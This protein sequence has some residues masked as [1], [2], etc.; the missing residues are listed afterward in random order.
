MRKESEIKERL[1]S[2]KKDL[3]YLKTWNDYADH[4]EQAG[5]WTKDLYRSERDAAS[6][7]ATNY[8]N[9]IR[10]LEWVLGDAEPQI[11]IKF[12]TDEGD[13]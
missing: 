8:A 9:E 13:E 4:Q 7:T 3:A 1:E 2:V 12:N 6:H 11:S 5:Y 10:L